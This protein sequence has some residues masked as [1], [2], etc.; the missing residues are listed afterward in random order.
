[1]TLILAALAGIFVLPSAAQMAAGPAFTQDQAGRLAAQARS[2]EQFALSQMAERGVDVS[3]LPKGFRPRLRLVIAGAASQAPDA[4][5]AA[6]RIAP[7]MSQE[8]ISTLFGAIQEGP[9]SLADFFRAHAYVPIPK[10]IQDR[11]DSGQT[12]TSGASFKDSLGGSLGKPLEETE[13]GARTVES[14]VVDLRGCA[15]SN[16]ASAQQHAQALAERPV[17]LK[18]LKPLKPLGRSL[19]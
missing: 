4:F 15:F 9:E 16:A 17:S 10:E 11:W 1:M 13:T 5:I 12:V 19:P 14:S 7:R 18:D 6:A 2:F 3:A 8:D